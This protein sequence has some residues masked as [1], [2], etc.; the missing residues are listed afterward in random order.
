MRSKHISILVIGL[1]SAIAFRQCNTPDTTP[2]EL[3]LS[4]QDTLFLV[5]NQAFNDPGATAYDE[6]EG[7]ISN[8]ILVTTR[9]NPDKT[10]IYKV[11]YTVTDKGGNKAQ[12]VRYVVVYNEAEK[13]AAVYNAQ[14]NGL[15][16]GTS[17]NYTDSLTFSETENHFLNTSNFLKQNIEILVYAYSDSAR[18]DHQQIIYNQDTV[19]I[20][21]AI[22]GTADTTKIELTFDMLDADS[23]LID[24]YNFQYQNIS[25]L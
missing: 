20:A 6:E 8:S 4:G 15:N 12:E 5:L 18:I 11:Y 2:P 13:Y 16:S 17:L 10:G 9:L 23:N 21:S 25:P 14:V 22:A 7:D 1:I 19:Y 24:S 3:T